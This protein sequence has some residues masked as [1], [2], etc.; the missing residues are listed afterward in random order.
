MQPAE[1]PDEKDDRKGNSNQPEQKAATHSVSSVRCMCSTNVPREARFRGSDS[2]RIGRRRHEPSN[3]VKDVTTRRTAQ[4]SGREE[5]TGWASRYE[6]QASVLRSL[7]FP[8]ET[9]SCV[10][11][12]S[13]SPLSLCWHALAGPAD[14][15]CSR[16]S[17]AR[18]CSRRLTSRPSVGATVT[19]AAMSGAAG[20]AT[21]APATVPRAWLLDRTGT[22]KPPRGAGIAATMVGTIG[23]APVLFAMRPTLRVPRSRVPPHQP[24]DGPTVAVEAD[25]LIHLRL[26]EGRTRCMARHTSGRSRSMIG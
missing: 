5:H 14:R 16:A 23:L 2:S 1:K 17:W 18:R 3:I 7:S 11:A 20:V 24:P 9:A 10:R 22:S 25:G 21:M 15:L 13:R 19:R 12:P 4:P 6:S 8:A 26:V